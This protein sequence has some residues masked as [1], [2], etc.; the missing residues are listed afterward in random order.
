MA[1]PP[2]YFTSAFD[3]ARGEEMA[4]P[5]A[6]QAETNALA[7]EVRSSTL[8]HL[9]HKPAEHKEEPSADGSL[10]FL[11]DVDNTLLDND[12]IKH[13]WNEQLQA[14]LGP[15]LT[16][17][18]WQIYEQVRKERAVVDIP[19]ALSRLREQTSNSELDEQ[20]EASIRSLFFEYPF[21]SRLYPGAIETLEHLRT[22]GLTVI[23]SDG[24]P[25]FQSE[26]IIKSHLAQAVEGRVLLFT[27]KQEH[28]DDIVRAYPV[29]HYVMVDDH[30][31]ILHESKQVMGDRLTTVFVK[32]GHYATD[33]LPHGFVPD[34]TVLHIADLSHYHKQELLGR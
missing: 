4:A 16:T 10:T 19:L 13:D 7:K 27:H 28:F 26:K 32:Q 11:L 30:P 21:E 31:Q 20:T 17:R 6:D 12:A 33:A 18:F 9:H 15:T 25:L 29:D 5:N 23:V 34:V 2:S 24:D 8:A 1:T 22:M 3:Q 14:A